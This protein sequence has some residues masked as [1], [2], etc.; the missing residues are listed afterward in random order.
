MKI[1]R[2]KLDWFETDGVGNSR[3][4]FEAGKFY[5][6]T[7]ESSSHVVQGA[8]EEVDAP[9]DYEKAIAAADKAEAK[10]DDAEAKAVEARATAEAA[11][12]AQ[13]LTAPDAPADM[14]AAA[15][16]A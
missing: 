3:A 12:A 14:P 7:D 6:V 5:P 13:A 10:L 8:A 1:I 15:A 2:Y 11:A 9:E 16:A 4:K